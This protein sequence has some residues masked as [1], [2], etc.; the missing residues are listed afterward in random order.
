MLELSSG[1]GNN[2]KNMKEN[3]ILKKAIDFL[4]QGALSDT[5]PIDI[6][7]APAMGRFRWD[8]FNIFD[9]AVCTSSGKVFFIQCT[10]YAHRGN[11]RQKIKAHFRE[12]GVIIPNAYI[13]S[14][15]EKKGLF[16][17]EEVKDYA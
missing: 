2:K 4:N 13:F 10:T 1:N 9:L 3:E 17:I 11:R 6:W 15:H 14:W 12:T 5:E 8:I 16:E 7:R